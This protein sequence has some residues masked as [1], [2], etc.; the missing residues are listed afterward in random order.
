MI[1]AYFVKNDN[2]NYEL[3]RFL[4]AQGC[5][6]GGYNDALQEVTDGYKRKHWIWYIFPQIKGLGFSYNSEYYG[7]NGLEEAKAYLEHEILGKRLREITNALL[8]HEGKTAREIF[9]GIDAMKAKSSMT[10]FDLIAPNDI[11]AHVL[12]K[13]YGG[14]RCEL[15]LKRMNIK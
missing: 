7:I 4:R 5:A 3:C 1:N 2:D 9:G 11:F 8:Q 6:S 10:L 14:Q 15:T 13:F 12:E